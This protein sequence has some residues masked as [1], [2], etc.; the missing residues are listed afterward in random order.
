[1]PYRRSAVRLG[2]LLLLLGLAL[3][4]VAAGAAQASTPHLAVLGFQEEDGPLGR[5]DASAPALST[6]GVDG[7]NLLPDGASVTAPGRRGLAQLAR[8]HQDGLR[9]ILLIGN[10][11]ESIED[12]NEATAYAMLGNPAHVQTVAAQLAGYV[13]GQ[14]WDGI[15]VDLESLQARDT[16]GLVTFVSDLR[17]DLPASASVNVDVTNYTKPAE[18]RASGYDLAALGAAADE[19]TLMAYDQHGPW[20]R[21]PGPVGALA[22]VRSGLAVVLRSIPASKIDLGIAGYGYAWRPSGDVQLSDEEARRLI[23]SEHA[24]AVFR[25]SVGEWTAKLSDGSTVW[26]SDARTYR[27]HA[28]LALAYHLHGVAV[29]S[30]GLSDP[31]PV[32]SG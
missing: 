7:V 27:L 9:A 6:V 5:I 29:W 26:F 18:Y 19:I 12:F 21:H 32:I 23:A 17:A 24:T 14:G 20:E 28:E 3:L 22:W 11:D 16:A 2:A 8:A 25:K 1:M 10:F 31:L 30:L 15:S 4:N 13:T